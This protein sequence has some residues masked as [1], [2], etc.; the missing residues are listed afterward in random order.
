MAAA[1]DVPCQVETK[2]GDV[3]AI[4]RKFAQR[5]RADVVVVGRGRRTDL[6]PLGANIGDII[7]RS[8]CPVITH[9][10]RVKPIRSSGHRATPRA[11]VAAVPGRA[12]FEMTA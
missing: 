8:P 5:W 7:R 2:T 4:L 1:I 3:A 9:A 12:S 6:W 11:A 10:A